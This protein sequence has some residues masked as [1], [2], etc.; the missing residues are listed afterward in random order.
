M[1]Y[2][3]KKFDFE[4]FSYSPVGRGLRIGMGIAVFIVG[5][6]YQSW[7]GLL[8]IFPVLSGIMNSCPLFIMKRYQKLTSR[9]K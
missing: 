7:W 5:I 1:K 6:I 4:K 9:S 3:M 8:G 2:N